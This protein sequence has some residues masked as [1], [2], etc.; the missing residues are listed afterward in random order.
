[1]LITFT[2]VKI[3]KTFFKKTIIKLLAEFNNENK[4]LKK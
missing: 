1:M 3:E 2:V 4:T